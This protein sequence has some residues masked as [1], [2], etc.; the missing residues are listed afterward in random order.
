LTVKSKVASAQPFGR[1]D[2]QDETAATSPAVPTIDAG[3]SVF[4]PENL[5]SNGNSIVTSPGE[6]ET[7][8]IAYSLI[9]GNATNVLLMATNG[10]ANRDERGHYL[11]GMPGGP[12]RPLGS[13]NKL[14]EDF[15]R[16]L[17]V[18]WTTHGSAVLD[19]IITDRPEI[20]FLAMTKLALVHPVEQSQPQ[21][22]DYRPRPR[23]Q[24]LE[25]LEQRAGPKARKMFERFL[26]RIDKL[27]RSEEEVDAA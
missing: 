11:K 20:L 23:E 13:R 4:G 15:L 27:E 2:R 18:A 21:E 8:L 16:D 24:A 3:K 12:G 7:T 25:M 17:H 22:F 9:N 14:S 26:A 5:S 6:K 1:R 19:R 10:S